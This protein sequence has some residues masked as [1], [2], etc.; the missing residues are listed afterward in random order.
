MIEI[1][2]KV[3]CS[4]VEEIHARLCYWAE[5]CS[6]MGKKEFVS[7]TENTDKPK[8]GCPSTSVTENS[9]LLSDDLMRENYRMTFNEIVTAL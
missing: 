9:H 7:E 3:G 6:S 2:K 1:V 5:Y 8:G 4:A